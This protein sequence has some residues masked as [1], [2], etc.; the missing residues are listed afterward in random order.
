MR[1]VCG[2]GRGSGGSAGYGEDIKY[3]KHHKREVNPM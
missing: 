2:W 1:E 3:H